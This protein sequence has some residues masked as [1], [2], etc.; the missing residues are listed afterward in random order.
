M[1]DLNEGWVPATYL[2][3]VY[4]SNESNKVIF[5][6]LLVI[7]PT[8]ISQSYWRCQK[9]ILLLVHILLKLSMS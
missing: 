2:E 4:G 7:Y 8:H 5:T 1:D 9:F 6:L 3:P